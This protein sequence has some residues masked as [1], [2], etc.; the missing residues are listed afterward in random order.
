MEI[1][2][3]YQAYLDIKN[4]FP[5]QIQ[6]WDLALKGKFPILIKAPTG[7]GK[8]EM[9]IAPFLRQFVEGKFTFAPR[10]IYVLP[11]RVLANTL[12]ER[13]KKYYK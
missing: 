9:V 11:M 13:I 8:T 3:F 1:S 2:K 10:L 6:F 5:H 12:A 4:P 7:A